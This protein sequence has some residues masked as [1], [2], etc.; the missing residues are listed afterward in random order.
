MQRG[1]KWIKKRSDSVAALTRHH[2]GR[3]RRP[4][5]QHQRRRGA[6]AK[7]VGPHWRRR[8]ERQAG[9]HGSCDLGHGGTAACTGGQQG[10]R[11]A[12][13]VA[14]NFGWADQASQKAD[15]GPARYS[16]EG[17][18]LQ[19]GTLRHAAPPRGGPR[20]L[21]PAPRGAAQPAPPHPA[22]C[23][24]QQ[25]TAGQHTACTAHSVHSVQHAQHRAQRS[26]PSRMIGSRSASR[27][28]ARQLA[29]R[30]ASSP[31]S[32]RS[33]DLRTCSEVA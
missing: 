24:V 10:S 12:R 30:E 13:G 20:A 21:G 29:G 11:A 2:H 31:S 1:T 14:A 22:G 9:A 6:P 5:R 15:G 4:R 25:H 27:T 23:G 7:A 17:S 33:A 3:R 19:Q 8:R 26:A 18:S 28:T 32:A 16:V